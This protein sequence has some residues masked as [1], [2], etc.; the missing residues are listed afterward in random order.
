MADLSSTVFGTSLD[1]T[2]AGR[3]ANPVEAGHGACR[4]SVPTQPL[5]PSPS[6]EGLAR[7]VKA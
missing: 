1:S 4:G 6:S 7:V 3:A 5:A 2:V